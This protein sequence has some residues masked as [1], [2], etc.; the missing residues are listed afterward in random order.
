MIKY[1]L[2]NNKNKN[3]SNKTLVLTKTMYYFYFVEL[4]QNIQRINCKIFC[5]LTKKKI[6]V[7]VIKNKTT[8][9]NSKNANLIQT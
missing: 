5:Y 3:V 7:R 2:I 6:I 4:A 8:V 1:L 9:I